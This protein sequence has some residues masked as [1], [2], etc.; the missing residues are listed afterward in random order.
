[1]DAVARLGAFSTEE[2]LAGVERYARMRWVTTLREIAPPVDPRSESP[3]ESVLRL[4]CLQVGEAALEPQ[5]SVVENGVE[6][7]RLDLA[8]RGLRLAIEY[9]GAEWHSDPHQREHDR[10]RREYLSRVHGWTFVVVVRDDLFG[11]DQVLLEARIR[12]A[13]VEARRRVGAR[14]VG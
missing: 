7:A 9:D 6:I 4:R 2:L 10:R 13:I 3:A 1:M 5:V 14:P 8:N 12:R 11:P